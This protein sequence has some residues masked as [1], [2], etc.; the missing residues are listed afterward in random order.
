[1]VIVLRLGLKDISAGGKTHAML[2]ADTLVLGKAATENLT[3]KCTKKFT[4][5]S[6]ELGDASEEPEPAPK[7]KGKSTDVY[8]SRPSPCPLTTV[9]IGDDE[10]DGPSVF[11]G[12]DLSKNSIE[13]GGRTLRKTVVRESIMN[14]NAAVE[15]KREE[16]QRELARAQRERMLERLVQGPNGT[17]GEEAAPK[18]KDFHS[19]RSPADFPS[20]AHRDFV[21]PFPH[22]PPLVALLTPADPRGPPA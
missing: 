14:N 5:V 19:Y 15:A 2:L 20:D 11:K 3:D 17:E 1:M 12:V 18:L 6:Y 13:K 10:L 4:E 7:K 9:R 22:N 8:A 16:H 21:R